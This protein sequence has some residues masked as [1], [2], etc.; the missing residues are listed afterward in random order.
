[1]PNQ[2]PTVQHGHRDAIRIVPLHV[3]Q[4]HALEAAAPATPPQLTYRNGPLLT[5]VEVFTVFWGSAWG[6]ADA[7]LVQKVND[8]FDAILVSPLIDQLSEYNV[9]GKIIGHGKR[10]GSIVI[11]QPAPHRTVADNSIQVLLQHEIQAN[12]AFPQPGPNTLYFVYLQRGVSVVQGG[13]RSCQAFCGYHDAINSQVFYAVMPY[14]GCTGCLGGM[15]PVDALTGTSSH[16]LCEAITDAVPGLGWYDDSNGEI[17][18]ICA[19]KFKQV[20]GYNV[21]LEWSN[22]ANKCV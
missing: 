10:T 15:E 4:G 8:F 20:N 18:D 6:G 14:P 2:K 3:P 12:S 11:Q 17:G 9:P 13:S 5:N 21:Q 16:E 1:M 19:W 7:A 22:K